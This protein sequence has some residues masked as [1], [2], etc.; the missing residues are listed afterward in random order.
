MT[1]LR[2]S[3]VEP[4]YIQQVWPD[5]KE[6][7]DIALKRG[8]SANISPD[9]N[10]DHVQ[11]YLTKGEWLL[12]VAADENKNIRGCATVSFSNYPMSRIAFVTAIGG[13]WI[14][15][16]QEF[17]KFKKLLQAHGATKIQGLGRD[18]IVRLWKRHNFESVNTL[19]EVD[20]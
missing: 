1:Q 11:S 18:S 8:K 9:Y 16:K 17:E 19:V 2:I 15:K 14:S 6:Y 13:R 3:H 20:I 4:N 10:L 12:V 7:I 5:V